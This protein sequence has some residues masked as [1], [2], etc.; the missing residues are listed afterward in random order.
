MQLAEKLDWCDS[1]TF[2]EFKPKSFI[3]VNCFVIVG[4]HEG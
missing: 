1:I 2:A 4:E 3:T